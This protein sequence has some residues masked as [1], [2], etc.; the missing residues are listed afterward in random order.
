M[1]TI[2]NK[3]EIINRMVKRLETYLKALPENKWSVHSKCD[4]W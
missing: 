4:V 2:S 1:A 3:I